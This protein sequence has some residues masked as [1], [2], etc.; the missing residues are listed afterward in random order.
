MLI[1]FSSAQILLTSTLFQLFFRRICLFVFDNS[2]LSNLFSGSRR[3]NCWDVQ[4]M[5]PSGG[6]KY[7]H[8]LVVVSAY[9]SFAK[10]EQRKKCEEILQILF[11]CNSFFFTCKSS[12]C[13]ISR[14]NLYRC[15]KYEAGPQS[16]PCVS[17][18]SWF[19]TQMITLIKIFYP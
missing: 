7:L 17:A 5:L 6:K 1:L 11:T 8:S 18:N 10:L 9:V 13:L 2:I 3:Y 15:I 4:A 19:L 16:I 14:R 12:S